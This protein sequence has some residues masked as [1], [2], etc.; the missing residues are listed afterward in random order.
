MY[1]KFIAA[2]PG[3]LLLLTTAA[4]QITPQTINNGGS[5]KTA[6]SI[7][8]EDAIGG[9]LVNTVTGPVFMY[10]QD[11]LQPG[12]GTTTSIPVIN[13]VVLGSGAGLDNAGT[14]FSNSGITI[15]FTLGEAASITLHQPGTMLTQGILQ[16]FP[17]A[18]SL[19]VTGLE[20]YAKRISSTQVQLD[21]KTIQEINNK[22]FYIERRK[23]NE[24]N[25]SAIDFISS[26]AVNGNS[27][28]PLQY[29]KPDNNNFPATTYYRLKQE[30]LDGR[31]S[32][33]PVRII[34]G[35]GN[36]Q[37][38]LQVW[39]VPATGPVNILVSG[40]DK[41][42][43]LL[44]FDMNGKQVQQHSIQDNQPLQLKQLTAGTY[45]IRLAQHRDLVQKILV[46]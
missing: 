18:V 41:T 19:P 5:S 26:K 34:A 16:P 46:Q 31:T 35:A 32:Y 44:V 14:S 10:T 22:G 2:L 38:I 36:K 25:F 7:I 3:L 17:A 20:F 42:D 13:N 30:D 21:W 11:F 43:Q 6:G 1:K 33:S 9:L 8:L 24:V 4:Q 27:S 39:P 28:V 37:T 12:A 23:E 29:T 45:I 15:D 40:I